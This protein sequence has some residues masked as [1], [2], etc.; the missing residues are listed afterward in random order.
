[1]YRLLLPLLF[2]G[3]CASFDNPTAEN[4]CKTLVYAYPQI[5]DTGTPTQ[6]AN[7]FTDDARFTVEKLNIELNGK[8]Q[9]VERFDKARHTTNTVHMMTSSSF[10]RNH[11]QLEAE[12]H[13]IL[14]LKD[15]AQPATTKVINGRYLDTF[16]YDSAR[17]LFDSRNVVIDR[18]GVL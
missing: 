3:G 8:T 13:F 14:L 7:L 6:Y 15:K 1:M 9:I 4:T 5:R 18:I 17:C 10:Y 12:S 16:S 2:A 11:D